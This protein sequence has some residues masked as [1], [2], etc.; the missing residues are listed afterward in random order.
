VPCANTP[1]DG[2]EADSKAPSTIAPIMRDSLAEGAELF[3]ATYL[4]AIG[5]RLGTRRDVALP[6]SSVP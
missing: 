3:M 5:N 6:V 4:L 2:P 1:H